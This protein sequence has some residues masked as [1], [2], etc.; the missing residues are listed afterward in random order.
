M[1]ERAIPAPQQ[2][3][4]QSYPGT[5]SQLRH[6]RAALRRFLAGCPVT[7]DAVH[8]ISELSAN[9]ITH[10]DSGKPGGTFTVRARH[11]PDCSVRA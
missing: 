10:S 11:C 8:L 3:W 5:P 4:E 9:A 1:Y 7:D 6:A 2:S